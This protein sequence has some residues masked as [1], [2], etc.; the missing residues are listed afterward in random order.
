MNA[1]AR[2]ATLLLAGSLI[3]A[4]AVQAETY[5][6]CTIL[7]DAASGKPLIHDGRCDER[8]TSGSTFKIAISLMGYDS[9]ILRDAHTPSLPFQPGYVDW[10]PGWNRCSRRVGGVGDMAAANG[11]GTALDRRPGARRILAGAGAGVHA[12]FP[13]TGSSRSSIRPGAIS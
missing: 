4:S 12:Q 13:K 2:I 1:R 5:I 6:D 7:A 3:Q 11:A 9:G 10:L 8:V